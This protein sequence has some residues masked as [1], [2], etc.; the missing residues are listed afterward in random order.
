MF[1][2]YVAEERASFGRS[3]AIC[4]KSIAFSKVDKKVEWNSSSTLHNCTCTERSKL[5]LDTAGN[6]TAE[7]QTNP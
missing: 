6:Q 7:I 3:R 5:C 2:M 1:Y 4:G